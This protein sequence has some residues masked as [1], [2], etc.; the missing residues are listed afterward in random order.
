LGALHKP[1]FWYRPKDSKK[2]RVLYGDLS[3][4]DADSPPNV[5]HAQPLP[6][7]SILR[8]TLPPGPASPKK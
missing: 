6:T 5:P 8:Y 2:Y 4:C 3:L 1:I 7:T